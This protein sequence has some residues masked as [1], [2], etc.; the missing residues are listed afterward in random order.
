MMRHGGYGN[1][2]PNVY[3]ANQVDQYAINAYVARVFGW[4]FIGLLVTALTTI[5]IIYGINVNEAFA[6]FIIGMQQVV[7]LVFI[8]EFFIVVA[9]S[10]RVT[11][12]N[13]TTAKLMYLVYAVLNGFTFG[14]FAVLY[15]YHSGGGI[16]TL[17]MAFGLTAVCFGIMAAYGLITKA[18]LTRFSNLLFMGLIGIIIASV[19][20]IFMG[21]GMLDFLICV[22]GLFLFLGITAH[23]TQMIKNHFAHVALSANANHGQDEYGY[24]LQQS[25]LAS[26]LAIV[27]ALML[28]LAFINIFMFILRLFGG[29]SRR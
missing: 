23:R 27:G 21:N 26:N 13:P 5:G 15:A 12:M 20:N 3:D 6:D 24:N 28:Y 18:D 14:L 29:G 16:H 8:A 1:E 11:K 4:M 7:F 19:A 17:G 9:I 10:A 2:H 25:A 22:I